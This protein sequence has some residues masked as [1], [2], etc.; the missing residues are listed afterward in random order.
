MLLEVRDIHTFY[1]TF[2]ALRGISVGVD[3]GEVVTILGQTARE[4]VR[5]F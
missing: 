1:G 4:K 2:Q 5:C 3:A